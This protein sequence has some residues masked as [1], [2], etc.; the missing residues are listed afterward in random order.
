MALLL[1]IFPPFSEARDWSSSEQMSIAA[2]E[3]LKTL[4]TAQG[5]VVSFPFEAPERAN[6]SFL[7]ILA[8]EPAGM[9]IKD[10]DDTQ[11]KAAQ[12]LLRASMSSQGYTKLTGVMRLEEVLRNLAKAQFASE[13]DSEPTPRQQAVMETRNPN[14]YA[15]AI[16]GDP[17]SSKWSWK[18]AGHH[19]AANFTVSDG[20]VS[21]T[22]MFLGSSPRII[23][24][25]PY[26]G[27][28]A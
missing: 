14:H 28:M 23:E 17:A 4:D 12:A 13:P 22:P 16:F 6:W 3:L 15:I 2:Q 10:M 9:L 7:P 25:G 24:S 18:I 27:T 19:A 26:A 11:R 5:K 1:A 20:R 8:V 21:F